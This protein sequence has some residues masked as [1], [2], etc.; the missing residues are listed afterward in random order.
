MRTIF[1]FLLFFYCVNFG[2]FFIGYTLNMPSISGLSVDFSSQVSEYGG[3][4]NTTKGDA[5]FTSANPFGDF[6]T[7]TT[8]F[9]TLLP[10]LLSPVGV[11]LP[12]MQNIGLNSAFVLPLQVITSLLAVMAMIYLITGR[13][14]DL[15][16]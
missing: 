7:G 11:M 4:V 5:S 8:T 1:S 12:L 13:G 3:I 2:M 10:K 6:V 14:S 15:S 16:I 9:F